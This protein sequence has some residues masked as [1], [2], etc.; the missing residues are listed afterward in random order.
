MH[1]KSL[2]SCP[3]LG[4]PIDCS[5]PGSSV[6]E[7]LQA[8]ILEWAALFQGIFATQGSNLCL[9]SLP[10]LA[11]GFFTNS[12]TWEDHYRLLRDMK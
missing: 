12:A 2:Q 4:D 8:R 3:T 10:A 11:G 5:L 7:I 1:A 6:H 9:L